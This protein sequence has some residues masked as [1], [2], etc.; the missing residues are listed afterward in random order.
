VEENLAFVKSRKSKYHY[1]DL[2]IWFEDRNIY[3][4]PL[5]K[6]FC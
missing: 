2:V 4:G 1:Q 5:R 6:V 3:F